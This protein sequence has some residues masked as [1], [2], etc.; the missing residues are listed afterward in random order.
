MPPARAFAEN[1][2]QAWNAHDLDAVLGFFAE[3]VLFSSPLACRLIP[4]SDGIVRGKTALRAYWE[5]GLAKAP[6]LHF[7]LTSVMEGIDLI[8]IGFRNEQDV[9]R[10]E[11]LKFAG[12]LVIE[13]HGTYPAD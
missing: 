11:V 10:C 7:E 3:D 12:G 4:D 6:A 8:V 1:W 2:A 5:A 9:E 13:G